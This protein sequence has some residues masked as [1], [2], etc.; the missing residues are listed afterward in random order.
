MDNHLFQYAVLDQ[1]LRGIRG[2]G[3]G[4]CGGRRGGWDECGL[5]A[6]GRRIGP[7]WSI[8]CPGAFRDAASG[9]TSSD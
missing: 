4:G 3:F 9:P 6:S 8:D 2:G 5:N 7:G 1:N